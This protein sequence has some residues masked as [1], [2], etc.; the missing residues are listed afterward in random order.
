M[1][2]K[3]I[4]LMILLAIGCVILTGCKKKDEA[5]VEPKTADE[6]KAEA[7]KEITEDNLEA[8]LQKEIEAL[9]ADELEDRREGL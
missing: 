6:Y 3:I 2:K 4:A 8:E 9:A 7:E 1:Y 5:P